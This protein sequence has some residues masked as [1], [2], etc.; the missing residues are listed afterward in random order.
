MQTEDLF[1]TDY[2]QKSCCVKW[3]IPDLVAQYGTS[4]VAVWKEADNRT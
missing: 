1:C 2:N 3:K 4:V